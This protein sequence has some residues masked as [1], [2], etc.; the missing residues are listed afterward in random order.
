MN[1]APSAKKNLRRR[2]NSAHAISVSHRKK[3]VI[4]QLPPPCYS[5]LVE[6]EVHAAHKGEVKELKK[7]EKI[8][9][10]LRKVELQEF[11]NYL[12]SPWRIFWA[13]FLAGTA[14]GLGFLLGA[15]IILT[16]VGFILTKVLSHV[17]YIGE[18]FQA[19]EVWIEHALKSK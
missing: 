2:G 12:H 16:V 19:V 3:F 4:E 10:K 5:E 13:N 11:T 7:L 9:H 14:R 18:F 8:I 17:P 1:S 15:T 6:S